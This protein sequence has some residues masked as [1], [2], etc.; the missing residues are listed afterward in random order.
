MRRRWKAISDNE[1]PVV[2]GALAK[3][4]ALLGDKKEVSIQ[5]GDESMRSL[6]DVLC[7]AK[8][9]LFLAMSG[10]AVSF[11]RYDKTITLYKLEGNG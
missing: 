9:R 5:K 3:C 7:K 10:V 8:Y 2:T 1:I 11:P 6:V 4:E